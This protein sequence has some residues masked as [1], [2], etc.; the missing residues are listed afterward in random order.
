M[1]F[2]LWPNPDNSTK[3][4]GSPFTLAPRQPSEG[5]VDGGIR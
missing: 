4:A 2:V 1:S 3:K 5:A